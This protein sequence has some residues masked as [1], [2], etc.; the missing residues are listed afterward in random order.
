MPGQL[1]FRHDMLFNI[2][3]EANWKDIK[4]Q[5]EK[6]IIYNNKHKNAERVKYDY[7]VGDKVLMHTMYW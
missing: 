6:L 7:H 3:H 4:G 5:K 2:A 1:V